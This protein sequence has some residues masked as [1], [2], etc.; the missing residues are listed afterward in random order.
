MV[1]YDKKPPNSVQASDFR[2]EGTVL[3]LGACALHF[4]EVEDI[5]SI[6]DQ[7]I[8]T[9]LP[10]LIPRLLLS[11]VTVFRSY[12]LITLKLMLLNLSNF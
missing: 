12:R 5:T 1:R 4:K 2:K 10:Y 11:P 6:L 8:A 7:L 3:A 9:L